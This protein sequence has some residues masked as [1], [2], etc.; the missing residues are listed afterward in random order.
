MTLT[1][2]HQVRETLAFLV[3]GLNATALHCM[4][5]VLEH[6]QCLK[7]TEQTGGRRMVAISVVYRDTYVS[8]RDR[9]VSCPH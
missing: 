5:I 2:W 8:T 7:H 4:H 1:D 9:I 3:K 6:Q